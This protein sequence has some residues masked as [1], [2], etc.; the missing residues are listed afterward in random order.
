MDVQLTTLQNSLTP[1][2]AQPQAAAQPAS[3]RPETGKALPVEGK[4]EP[5]PR[6]KPQDV[7]RAVQ[8]IQTFLSTIQR[9]L[10]FHVDEQSGRT[11]ITVINPQT[12]E[13][14]RQIPGEEIL[15][16][17]DAMRH[18]GPRFVSETV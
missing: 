13:V 2:R 14:V 4:D 7:Q 15:Q 17:A 10:E 12:R 18:W 6:P 5:K 16:L 9:E 11:V 3:V 1:G 8:Q